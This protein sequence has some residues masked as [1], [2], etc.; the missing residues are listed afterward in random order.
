[1]N[2]LRFADD[3]LIITDNLGDAKQMII[4]LKQEAESVGLNINFQKTQLLTNLDANRQIDQ[5]RIDFRNYS[6]NRTGL[7]RVC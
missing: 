6:P 1:M 3:I 4:E 2:H 5:V 7:G